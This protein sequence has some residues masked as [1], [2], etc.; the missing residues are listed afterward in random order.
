MILKSVLKAAR[1][2][3]G[4]TAE[5]LA[6]IF[7]LKESHIIEIEESESFFNFYSMAIKVNAAKKIG[8]YLGLEESE[9]LI[10]DK[11]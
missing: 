10:L 7:C 8:N 6:N 1:E 9:Y 3:K 2:E 11:K 5:E 4:L